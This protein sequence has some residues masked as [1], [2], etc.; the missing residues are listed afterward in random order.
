MRKDLFEALSPREK[1]T[2]PMWLRQQLEGYSLHFSQYPM[3]SLEVFEGKPLPA[4]GTKYREIMEQY[5]DLA[6]T[7]NHL[8]AA[9]WHAQVYSKLTLDVMADYLTANGVS[10]EFAFSNA[11]LE[12]AM[13][14][15]E[16]LLKKMGWLDQ[17]ID[18]REFSDGTHAVIETSRA[19]T[20]RMRHIPPEQGAKFVRGT[21]WQVES[22]DIS[23]IY[24]RTSPL[25]PAYTVMAYGG[26][27]THGYHYERDRTALTL[28]E[29]ARIQTFSDDFVF[30]GKHQRAQI[31]EAV[32]PL[33]GQCIAE[34]V[35]R[36]LD[37]TA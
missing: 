20:A 23:F 35:R 15:H 21:P 3:T 14:Q 25:K 16:A 17:P 24:R 19:V 10:R 2:V 36:I 8:Q 26:G 5:Q 6:H 37:L 33:L 11:E 27:G 32:P 29:R 13:T 12:E 34:S 22:K 31:G 30:L 18:Q 9:E 1:G 28:R 4:L 7:A